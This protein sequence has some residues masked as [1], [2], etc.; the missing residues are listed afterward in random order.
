MRIYELD[1]YTKYVTKIQVLIDAKIHLIS[2]TIKQ[3]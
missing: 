3:K 2:L 1:F